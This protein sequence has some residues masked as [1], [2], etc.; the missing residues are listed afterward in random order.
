MPVGPPSGQRALQ[1]AELVERLFC[2]GSVAE[3]E[4]SETQL[5]AII[6][7]LLADGVGSDSYS[8]AASALGA[9]GLVPKI[10]SY[11]VKAASP[12]GY[13]IFLQDPGRGFS[14]QIHPVP[15]FEL[16]HTLGSRGFSRVFKMPYRVWKEAYEPAR[17]ERW[18]LGSADDALDRF[19][20]VPEPGDVFTVESTEDVH[21]VLGCLVE[22]FATNSTDLVHRLHDQNQHL[23][24]PNK[25]RDSVDS[26]LLNLP[27]VEPRRRWWLDGDQWKSKPMQPLLGD[28]CRSWSV[29]CGP[30]VATWLRL[31]RN[32]VYRL[33]CDSDRLLFG[34]VFSGTAS[35][36]FQENSRRPAGG[37]I[38]KG[39]CFALLPGESA[40]LINGGM[41]ELAISLHHSPIGLALQVPADTQLAQ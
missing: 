27:V 37:D 38:R 6:L 29:S 32:G 26:E 3:V 36:S 24:V 39:S 34:R 20:V 35:F 7:S 33:R 30:L 28:G 10:K 16:F 11:A 14:F 2:G 21:T 13:A 41:E 23:T 19:A 31:N 4:A 1:L 40:H 8:Q 18:L 12:T 15:K 9:V 17:M 5:K 22:E 25:S